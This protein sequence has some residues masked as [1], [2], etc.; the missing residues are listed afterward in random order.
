MSD[1]Q[2]AEIRRALRDL[3]HIE[4]KL[5]ALKND[6]TVALNS[7]RRL[8]G[9]DAS[10]ANLMINIAMVTAGGIARHLAGVKAVL[11]AANLSPPSEE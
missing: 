6:L 3:D 1:V 8:D 10:T 2:Q 9:L 4:N 5:H 7:A 11:E